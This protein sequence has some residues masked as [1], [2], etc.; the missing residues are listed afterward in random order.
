MPHSVPYPAGRPITL[1][2]AEAALARAVIEI[3]D[4]DFCYGASQALHDITL[5]IHQREVTAFIGPSG[6]GKST[7]RRC[8]N[9]MNDLSVVAPVSSPQ[10]PL[11]PLNI[12]LPLF[13]GITLH[14]PS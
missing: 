10:I 11:D 4:V 9:R 14:D 6:C 1:G 3:D 12:S 7:L 2:P 13:S 8:L 5:N